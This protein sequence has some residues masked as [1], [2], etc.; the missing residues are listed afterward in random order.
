MND[1]TCLRDGCPNSLAG[2]RADA[3]FCTDAC[4]KAHRREQEGRSDN[5]HWVRGYWRRNPRKRTSSAAK[6]GQAAA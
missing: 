3:L 2:K 4:S 6:A 1:R 5:K